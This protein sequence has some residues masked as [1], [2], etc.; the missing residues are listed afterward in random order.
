LTDGAAPVLDH[1]LDRGLADAEGDRLV[2]LRGGGEEMETAVATRGEGDR[3]TAGD[4]RA[5]LPGRR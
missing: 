3:L 2:A 4:G 5:G 1:D